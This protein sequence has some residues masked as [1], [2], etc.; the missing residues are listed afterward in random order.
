MQIAEN[1]HN[2]IASLEVEQQ[3]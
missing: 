2:N 1:K 3:G